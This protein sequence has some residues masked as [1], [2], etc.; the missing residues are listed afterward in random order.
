MHVPKHHFN[1]FGPHQSEWVFHHVVSR[2]KAKA[3]DRLASLRRSFEKACLEAETPPG[4]RQNDLRHR[5]ITTWLAEEK[6]TVHVKEAVGHADLQTT[7]KYTHLT[8]EHLRSLV[9]DSPKERRESLGT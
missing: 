9:D 8:K 2:G 3:G 5:R 6:H 7:M 4:F 1:Q